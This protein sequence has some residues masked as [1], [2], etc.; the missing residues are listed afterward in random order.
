MES[1]NQPETEGPDST[2][3][4]EQEQTETVTSSIPTATTTLVIILLV[5]G[6]VYAY[7]V[8][9]D[10]TE[11]PQPYNGFTFTNTP[12]GY[13]ETTVSGPQGETA[14]EFRRH[15]RQV[16]NISV[17]PSVNAV[18]RA[19]QERNGSLYISVSPEYSTGGR[20]GIGVYE[21]SKITNYMFGIGTQGGVTYQ[22]ATGDYPVVTCENV[23]RNT[24]V[25]TIEKGEDTRV[26]QENGCIKLQAQTASDVIRAADRIVYGLLDIIQ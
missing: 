6:G 17:D 3:S 1:S 21:L 15:P 8:Y 23:T 18:I 2:E 9:A 12:E 11:Q 13:Y 22:N 19:I 26:T 4:S 25:L 24:A 16:E 20:I 10:S 14:L 5:I 7:T